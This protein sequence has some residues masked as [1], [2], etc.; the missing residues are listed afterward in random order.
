ML[1]TCSN[2]KILK[3]S[4]GKEIG[5]ER[6]DHRISASIKKKSMP[7]LRQTRL[8]QYQHRSEYFAQQRDCDNCTR[9]VGVGRKAGKNP[10]KYFDAKGVKPKMIWIAEEIGK[11]VQ[12]LPTA[13][14]KFKKNNFKAGIRSLIFQYANGNISKFCRKIK[15]SEYDI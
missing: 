9:G 4:G 6:D 3:K 11:I 5:T 2:S 8:V 1:E 15:I 12:S 13:E 14:L 10:P 7:H